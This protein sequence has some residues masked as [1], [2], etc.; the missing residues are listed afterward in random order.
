MSL[1]TWLDAPSTTRGIRFA[2]PGDAW[3]LHT[4]QELA[5]LTRRMAG[6]L[7][8]R[9]VTTGDGVVLVHRTGPAFVG[10]LFGTVLAGGTPTPLAPPMTFDDRARYA[11]HVRGIQAVARPVL[12]VADDDLA[13]RFR[14]IVDVP[15]V[16]ASELAGGPPVAEPPP[17]AEHVLLQFTSGSSGHAR[18]V[19]ISPTALSANIAAIRGWLGMTAEDATATWL[20]PHHD[21]GLIG[22]LLTP[23][24]N[25]SDVWLMSPEQFVRDPTRFVRC[26][27]GTAR[28]TAMPNFGLAHVV[29]RVRAE[30]LAGADFGEW[31]ALIIGAERVDPATLTAFRDLLAPFGF[32]ERTFLPAYGLAEAT[33]AVTGLP[34]AEPPT[35]VPMSDLRVG[36]AVDLTTG[37][38]VT[39]CGRPLAGV[40]VIVRDE[41]GQALPDGHLGEIAVRGASVPAGYASDTPFGTRFTDGEVRTGD[42]G[43]LVDGQLFV[44][45]RLGDSTKVRGRT[46][47]AEDVESALAAV[48]LPRETSV[49]LLG[50]H[51]GVPMAIALLERANANQVD[52]A[53]TILTQ[54][55]EGAHPVVI[56]A[57][58]RTIERTSSGKPRRRTLWTRYTQGLL[59]G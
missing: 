31:R 22:C 15:V 38:P 37:Q 26:F 25:G 13:P 55:A 53:T 10:A 7:V 14:E 24:V 20:P 40:E 34:L 21:M 3:P 18:G 16:T 57:P 12:L 50:V 56:S 44:L 45:G 36:A 23:V 4:Y 35:V 28:L 2:E 5:D 42:S 58:P 27:A 54:C 41:D 43:V 33:L 29:R 30:R 19:P 59:P 1:L 51:E 32:D 8:D 48:G 46:V 52:T 39:G 6:G 49:V 17:P 11:D 9:G 47:F